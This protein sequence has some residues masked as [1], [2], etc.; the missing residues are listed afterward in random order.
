M[1]KYLLCAIAFFC[2]SVFGT[3]ATNILIQPD[4]QESPLAGQALSADVKVEGATDLYTYVFKIFFDNTA[5]KFAG[6]QEEILLKADG[7]DTAPFVVLGWQ[8]GQE[9]QT[10]GFDSI[11]DNAIDAINSDGVVMISNTRLSATK[12]ISGKGPLVILD[13]EVIEPKASTI[14]LKDVE[15]TDFGAEELVG[16]D[17]IGNGDIT[18]PNLPPVADA[19]GD[20]SGTTGEAVSFDAS[21]ST[22]ED[23]T[24]ESYSW[25]FGDGSSGDGQK[26]THIYDNAGTYQVTLTVTDD[27]SNSSEDE[28]SVIVSEPLPPVIREHELGSQMLVLEATYDE[29]NKH[30]HAYVD[31]WEGDIA[32]EAG[33][34]LE[35]QVAMFSG[36]P[37]FKGTVDLHTSDG[38]VLSQSDAKDQNDV[39]ASPSADLSDYAWDEWYH[40]KISLDALVGKTLDGVM[41]A[42]SSDEHAADIFRVY[43]DNIQITDGEHIL[44]AIYLDDETIPLTGTDT[45]NRTDF[46]ETEGMSN[47]SVSIVGATPVTPKGKLMSVWG[48]IKVGL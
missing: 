25:D 46:V 8:E 6:I 30:G 18:A 28:I 44:K 48:K 27:N 4:T 14:E 19:G 16:L 5:L 2:L 29:A 42:T 45:S 10:V 12:G 1:R 47:Y 26:A 41:I 9:G 3:Q 40:R 35:F 33:M 24:I 7:A 21:A 13:F 34:F 15:L 22:D 11:D 20:K 31:I 32:I 37:A 36:N 43:V 39:S 38:S 23:G 17:G